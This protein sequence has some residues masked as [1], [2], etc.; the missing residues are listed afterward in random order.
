MTRA[1]W[2]VYREAVK[3]DADIYSFHDAEMIPVALLLRA[4]GKKVVYN[5]HDD[6][7]VSLLTKHYIP[8]W[9]RKPLAALA[10][11]LENTACRFFS[12]IIPAS[13]GLAKKY[14][15][16]NKQTVVVSN[17]V[18]LSEIPLPLERDWEHGPF[19]VTYVGFLDKERQIHQLV[20]AMGL[21]P[22]HLN[23]VL[24][25]GGPF[26]SPGYRKEVVALSEWKSVEELGYLN[27]P[28]MI[29][30]LSTSRIGVVLTVDAAV[31][32]YGSSNKLFDY[33]ASA[34]PIVATNFPLWREIIEEA[35]CG[36]TVDSND[37]NAIAEALLYLLTHPKEADEMG[38]RGR[39]AVE[40]FYSWQQEEEKLIQLFNTLMDSPS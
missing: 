28:D 17:Y 34:I 15:R 23:V 3:L 32:R 24:T 20:M 4:S 36:L 19:T 26:T 16:L 29:R 11:G 39:E 7:T 30:V 10:A 21:L 25:L 12:G 22:K 31:Q 5:I 9:L 40:K 13:P 14:A 2:Q 18:D 8:L 27:R 1:V 38:R 6:A 33:M 35:G 37:P